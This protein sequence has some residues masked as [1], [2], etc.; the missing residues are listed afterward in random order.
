MGDFS[1][2]ALV[3]SIRELDL[4]FVSSAVKAVNV[5]LTFRNWCIGAYI[6]EFELHGSNRAGYGDKLLFNLSKELKSTGLNN[7]GKRELS[8]YI[9]FYI[10][11]P[12]VGLLLPEAVRIQYLSICSPA[13]GG[14][15]HFIGGIEGTLS[16]QFRTPPE[17]L[18]SSLSFSHISEIM[19]IED[20]LKRLF[21][22]VECIRG[23]WSVRELKRQIGSLY[24]ERSG[25]SENKEALSRLANEG[26]EISSPLMLI[27]DPYVF[28]FLGLK[29]VEVMD[30]SEF[31]SAL[32]E[33]LEHFLLELGRGFCFEARQKRILIGNEYYF[34]DLLFYHRILKCHILVELKTE[35]MSH[36]AVGQLNTYLN[37]FKANEMTEGDNPPVGILLC[38]EKNDEL[39]RYATAGIANDLFVSKYE[40][41]LPSTLELEKFVADEI[42]ALRKKEMGCQS[43]SKDNSN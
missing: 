13:D 19:E 36:E 12:D 22:E 29:P 39:V 27:R 4:R 28:E 38:T 40:V 7:C 21:Y 5:N 16:P 11:Y 8:R 42:G 41:V 10:R 32:L 30:E 17:K 2:E 33:K 23:C 14:Q 37:W 31:E 43:V 1:F 25:L 34:V 18:I 20:P 35:K 24:Y 15:N 26:A 6:S 3:G 9:R